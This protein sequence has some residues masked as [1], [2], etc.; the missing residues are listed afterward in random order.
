MRGSEQLRLFLNYHSYKTHH[1]RCWSQML[2]YLLKRIYGE[3]STLYDAEGNTLNIPIES[4]L[5]NSVTVQNP[6]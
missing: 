2:V 5:K 3:R 4:V 6:S 1:P